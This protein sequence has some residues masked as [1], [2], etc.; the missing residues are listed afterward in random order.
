MTIRQAI[1]AQAKRLG[2]TAYAIAKQS[3]RGGK[4]AVS[5][6]HVLSYM[7]GEKDMTSKRLDAVMKVLGITLT[8]E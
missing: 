1:V 6:D 4:W 8:V 5:P 7:N 3:K 2:L